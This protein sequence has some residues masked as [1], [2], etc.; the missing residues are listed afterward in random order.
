MNDNIEENEYTDYFE[1]PG[2]LDIIFV[3]MFII[4]IFIFWNPLIGT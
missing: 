2:C 1:F 3:L 4:I